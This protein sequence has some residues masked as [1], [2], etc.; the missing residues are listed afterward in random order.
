MLVKQFRD[1]CVRHSITWDILKATSCLKCASLVHLTIPS[2]ERDFDAPLHLLDPT[3]LAE[4]LTEK[5]M[6][7]IKDPLFQDYVRLKTIDREH[8]VRLASLRD[9]LTQANTAFWDWQRSLPPPDQ[10]GTLEDAL[11]G[12]IHALVKSRE[13]LAAGISKAD[14]AT[15]GTIPKLMADLVQRQ[16]QHDALLTRVMQSRERPEYIA[17]QRALADLGQFEGGVGRAKQATKLD[18]ARSAVGRDCSVHGDSFEMA[19]RGVVRRFAWEATRAILLGDCG[20]HP[21]EIPTNFSGYDPKLP[22]AGPWPSLP[23]LR[24]TYPELFPADGPCPPFR[25]RL[26]RGVEFAGVATPPGLTAEFDW[27]VVMELEAGVVGSEAAQQRGG[28]SAGRRPAIVLRHFECKTRAELA[29]AQIAKLYGAIGFF[30]APAA[31]APAAPAA[32]PGAATPDTSPTSSPAAPPAHSGRATPA[33]AGVKFTPGPKEDI[34]GGVS[35]TAAITGVPS[36][37]TGTMGTEMAAI[38]GVPSTAPDPVYFHPRSFLGVFRHFF[39]GGAVYLSRPGTF[40][41]LPFGTVEALLKR[42]VKECDDVHNPV[43]SLRPADSPSP[44]LGSLLSDVRTVFE[45]PQSTAGWQMTQRLARGGAFWFVADLLC[46]GML[47]GEA[48][49]STP[50]KSD[51]ASEAASERAAAAAPEAASEPVGDEGTTPTRP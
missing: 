7:R 18:A 10:L 32:A 34:A 8:A 29:L 23:L 31:S 22:S 15:S 44:L 51:A 41:M 46:P 1:V 39:A 47:A 13:K 14:S 3:Q 50:P 19:C 24:E 48:A 43:A 40:H 26:F 42:V 28:W 17:L 9:A 16:T 4:F 37:T 2:L 27:V 25:L 20:S 38:A 35:S 30:A 11:G 45:D 5:Y 12:A 33:F 6:R 49:A 36:T 21:P